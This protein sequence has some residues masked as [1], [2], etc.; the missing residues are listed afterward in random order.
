[1]EMRWSLKE[2][3]PSFASPAFKKDVARLA[4]EITALRRW[5]KTRLG[6]EK[7]PAKTIE[8]YL[9]QRIALTTLNEKLGVFANLSF[10]VNTSDETAKQALETLDKM[11]AET[12]EDRVKFAQWLAGVK[13]L[14][15]LAKKSKL[16]AEHLFHLR[17][18]QENTKHMLSEKEEVLFA[19]MR[20]TGSTAWGSLQNTLTSTLMVPVKIGKKTEELPLPAAR[21]LAYDP[22][23]T[24]RKAAFE[25]ELAAYAKVDESSAACLN[26]IK[27]EVITTAALRGF[28]SPLSMTLHH[29]R[30]DKKTL[31]ALLTAMRES[32]PQFRKYL[33]KK[34]KLLGHKGGLPF[35]D[36]FAPVGKSD[37][38][39]T[40]DIAH[41]FIVR[42]F[43]S[44]SP[45]LGKFAD[46]AF[47]KHWIDAEPRKGK[48][49]GAFCYN[50][51]PIGESRILSNFTG[52][53]T[54]MTTLAHELGH[55]YH[56]HC[57]RSESFLNSDYP[58]PLAETASIF[59]ETIVTQAAIAAADKRDVAAI[60]ENQ[61]M[62]ATQVI[63]DI[64][65]RYLFETALFAGRADSSVPVSRLKE[66]MLTAQKEAY[67]DGLDKDTLHPYMWLCKP[68][69]Y[70][71]DHNFYNFPYAFGLLFAKGLY[72]EY[73]KRGDT[74]VK[75]YD[76]LL[77]ETGKN[78]IATVAKLMKIDVRKPDFWRGSLA[79]IGRDID[80]FCA[81]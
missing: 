78:D 12:A 21:N 39:F 28:D 10:A 8:E 36:L 18:I 55:A 74:F 31:D 57:L 33:R 80:T 49:G 40:Y 50:I 13:Q 47:K 73:L 70:D 30:M 81:L 9:K 35:Y 77:R 60:L 59:C 1:M 67:G 41:Q 56:G 15:A 2:L 19:K 46:N 48:V 52:S 58:M 25:A 23:K 26:A 14:D 32:L 42:N 6:K 75:D 61:L 76:R 22:D 69:Y 43:S 11:I 29:S 62:G 38:R 53:F 16:I 54:N 72:A 68:H 4:A 71:P 45:E 27:G 37:L 64:Y 20:M 34:A 3:Y 63:V 79:I 44:F 24:V 51:H 5:T 17:E 7:D 65:S 66:L